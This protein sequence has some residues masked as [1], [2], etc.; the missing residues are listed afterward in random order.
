M[1]FSGGMFP[2]PSLKLFTL[3][4]HP[5]LVNDILPTSLSI[6]ALGKVLNGNVGLADILFEIVG[7]LALTLL[8]SAVGI[9]LFSRRHMR[10][11]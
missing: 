3:G 9:W 5:F 10:A 7:I 8:Y 6:S 11:H 2:L 1:F 4:G